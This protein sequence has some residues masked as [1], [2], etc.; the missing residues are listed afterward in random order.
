MLNIDG[1]ELGAKKQ[2]ITVNG[3]SYELP[4]RTGHLEKKLIEHDKKIGKI[5]EYESNKDLIEILLGKEA[6][7]AIFPEGEDANLD[8]I[9]TLAYY[10][11]TAFNANQKALEKAEVDKQ[12]ASV[13]PV[14]EMLQQMNAAG[15]KRVPEA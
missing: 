6:F 3:V 12:M 14:M 15:S 1:K 11:L 5:S 10:A 9:S 4:E 13:Q 8:N 7:A 2:T